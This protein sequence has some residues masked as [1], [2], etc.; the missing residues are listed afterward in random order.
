MRAD[1]QLVCWVC[2]CLRVSR[3]LRLA[4]HNHLAHVVHAD[5]SPVRT[6]D[7]L[8]SPMKAARVFSGALVAEREWQCRLCTTGET[9]QAS[10][11]PHRAMVSF[12]PLVSQPAHSMPDLALEWET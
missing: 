7:G 9:F 5:I 11:E 10:P 1:L 3:S 12:K 6:S 4:Q 8:E 2:E